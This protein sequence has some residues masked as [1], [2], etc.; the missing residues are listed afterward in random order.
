MGRRIDDKTL[1]DIGEKMFLEAY[2]TFS[3]ADKNGEP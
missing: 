1:S 2:E 3:K